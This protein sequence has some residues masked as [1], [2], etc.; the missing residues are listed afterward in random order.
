MHID[1]QHQ[2]GS[3]CRLQRP[4]EHIAEVDNVS[5]TQRR[6]VGQD[7]FQRGAI[8]MD[9]SNRRKPHQLPR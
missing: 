6:D 8:P 3:A 9:V 7:S 5:D 2:I 1:Q 4:A